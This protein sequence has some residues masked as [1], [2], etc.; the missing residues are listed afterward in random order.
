MLR[1]LLKI[2]RE[3]SH[4]SSTF[5]FVLEDVVWTMGSFCTLNRKPFYAELLA[6]QFPPPYTSDSFIH[7][8]RALDFRAKRLH[9]ASLSS[10][11]LPYLVVLNEA[12]VVKQPDTEHG[13]LTEQS[14]ATRINAEA[15]V[16]M[17]SR[18]HKI[19]DVNARQITDYNF[20]D[21][22][23]LI[24]FKAF[25]VALICCFASSPVM[26]DFETLNSSLILSGGLSKAQNACD[27][28]WLTYGLNSGGT[29]KE[30]HTAL[31]L[32]YNYKFTPVWGIEA[33]YG[34]L[35][36]ATGNGTSTA[37]GTPA[38][39]SMKAIGWSFAGTA[40]VPV[41]GGFSL[42]GKLGTV[43]AEFT[44]TIHTTSTTGQVMQ[45]ITFNGA[46][47]TRQDKNALTYGIGLQYELN[48]QFALR[49][50]YENFGKY[51]MY[52]S[53]G[54]SAPRIGLSLISAGLVLKF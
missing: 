32:A 2:S 38:T 8:D 39:W 28:P 3:P 27:S 37:Y 54:I 1:R 35:G 34:D 40:A 24:R 6:K 46:P 22:N 53:Y 42:L 13:T 15:S 14:S 17:K 9:S 51:D 10:L 19:Q 29:C 18:L 43:R 26:A 48:K 50:Q 20:G 16:V 4:Y 7:T 30:T 11:N 44:E 52:G 31:R 33:S 5:A 49:A 47:I 21:R 41:G 36:N 45:G 23:M 12:E 25:T